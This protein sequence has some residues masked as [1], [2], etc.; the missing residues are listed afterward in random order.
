METQIVF[1]SLIPIIISLVVSVSWLLN[2]SV[3]IAYEKDLLKESGEWLSQR[4]ILVPTLSVF[5]LPILTAY[6]TLNSVPE[7][8]KIFLPLIT[9]IAGQSL[10]KYEKQN[11]IRN[12]QLEVLLILRRKFSIAR[13]KI[14][15]NNGVLQLELASIDSE[16]RG[17]IERRL[18]FLDAIGDEFSRL[19]TFLTL[20]KDGILS[21]DDRVHPSLARLTLITRH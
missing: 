8:L 14:S 5:L 21:I 10:G 9:F 7:I 16:D 12:R 13:K 17:F 4:S 1:T 6:I 18:Q 19:D 11:E 2:R 15:L 20:T 3:L